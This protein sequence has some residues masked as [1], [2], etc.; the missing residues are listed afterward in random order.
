M[1]FICLRR[2]V[3]PREQWTTSVD[4]HLG[5]MKQQHEAGRILF[6]GPG[7]YV[8]RAE[9]LGIY[10]IR[11]GSRDEAVTI[12]NGDPFTAAGHCAFDLI[13]WEVH[14]IFG[15]GAFTMQGLQATLR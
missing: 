9:M 1:W 5:W 12:A 11:A 10:L 15:A 3:V 4:D 6:S 8:D 13:E 14:Q 7:H 2:A